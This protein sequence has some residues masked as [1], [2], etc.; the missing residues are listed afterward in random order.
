MAITVERI[1]GKPATWRFI[2]T[3]ALDLKD[4]R[5]LFL[6]GENGDEEREWLQQCKN[7]IV[8]G[9]DI[10]Y[11]HRRVRD[12]KK[13]KVSGVYNSLMKLSFIAKGNTG[14]WEC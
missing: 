11:W 6:S 10:K 7:R 12:D 5:K 4:N 14:K 2:S 13:T 9:L 8:D 3:I 1:G